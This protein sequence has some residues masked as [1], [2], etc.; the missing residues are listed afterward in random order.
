MAESSNEFSLVQG[1]S[2]LLHFPHQ[3]HLLVH[4]QQAALC[5]LDFKR[6]SVASVR[7]EGFLVQLDGEGVVVGHRAC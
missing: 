1:I 5:D 3:R 7:T 4:I 6:G 2:S